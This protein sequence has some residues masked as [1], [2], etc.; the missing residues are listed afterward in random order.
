MKASNLILH[1]Q[2][3]IAQHGDLPVVF[4]DAEGSLE[5]SVTVQASF[6]LKRLDSWPYVSFEPD[7][8]KTAWAFEISS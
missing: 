6:P 5:E 2:A 4:E 3:L 8:S 1:L 7:K